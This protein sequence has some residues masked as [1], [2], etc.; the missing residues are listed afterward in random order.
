M[1]RR[2]TR[3]PVR[4][5]GGTLSS[6]FEEIII[7]RIARAQQLPSRQLRALSLKKLSHKRST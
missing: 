7:T 4:V 6:I 2:E 3:E 1:R 5:F